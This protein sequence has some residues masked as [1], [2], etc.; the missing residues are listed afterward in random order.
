VQERIDDFWQ[1]AARVV[2]VGQ[3]TGA[4]AAAMQDRLR[5]SFPVLGDP[6]HE[7]Y[8]KLGLGRTGWW[9]LTVQP[10]VEDFRGALR[11]L[12]QADLRASAN[13]RSDVARLGGTAVIAQ[14]G[15]LAYLHRAT[16]TT[17]LAPHRDVIEAIDAA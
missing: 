3:G 2:A 14:G 10:F 17:D 6:G 15:S 9:G 5:L 4:E 11:N 12:R 13:P 1:R 7:G 16:R 8:E